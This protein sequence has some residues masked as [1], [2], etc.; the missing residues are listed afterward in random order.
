MSRFGENKGT[1]A[2]FPV[3]TPLSLPL[4]LQC[5]YFDTDA[6]IFL[7]GYVMRYFTAA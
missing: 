2:P 7:K 1:R 4:T 6:M 5:Y 3:Q